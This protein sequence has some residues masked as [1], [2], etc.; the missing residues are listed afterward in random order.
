MSIVRG[1]PFSVT[2]TG[3]VGSATLVTSALTLGDTI[4][5]ETV[6]SASLLPVNGGS[7]SDDKGNTWVNV[8]EFSGISAGSGVFCGIWWVFSAAAGVTT[9]TLNPS[10]GGDVISATGRPVNGLTG[11][12]S[13]TAVGR[14][15][16]SATAIVTNVITTT[17]P[18]VLLVAVVG[19]FTGASPT[20]TQS[21]L[22][23]LIG[24]N[25]DGGGG[26]AINAIDL[27]LT[28]SGIFSA[29]W[30]MG[31]ATTVTS[32]IA[33]FKGT[34]PPPTEFGYEHARSKT[35]RSG[36]AISGLV[37]YTLGWKINGV[38]RGVHINSFTITHTIGQPSTCSFT[39]DG[40]QIVPGNQV[41]ISNDG[42]N[43]LL[44]GGVILPRKRRI[45]T[46][47]G[48]FYDVQCADWQWLMDKDAVVFDNFDSISINT[49]IRRVLN[50][51]VDPAL[52]IQ[53]GECSGSL[54][55]VSLTSI[56]D[57]PSALIA[58]ICASVKAYWQL[59]P[60]KYINV[61]QTQPSHAQTLQ[62]RNNSSVK[63]LYLGDDI[64]QIRNRVWYAGGGAQTTLLVPMGSTTIPVN[65]CGWYSD[66][67]GEGLALWLRF[68]Y[69][70]KSVSS[71]VGNLTGVA[72]L[73]GPADVPQG[74][75]VYVFSRLDDAT[76][77]TALATTLGGG[78]TG[79][80]IFYQADGNASIGEIAGR[81]QQ[82]RDF[83][84]DPMYDV[85]F[86]AA[87]PDYLENNA[88]HFKSGRLVDV[89]FTDAMSESV[90]GNFRVSSVT[91]TA[92][93]DV[94]LSRNE[95]G[96]ECLAL[97]R[98]FTFGPGVR[99]GITDLLVGG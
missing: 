58:R 55:T 22:F 13:G 77:Q 93:G 39:T 91:I 2:H 98:S 65:E 33:G 80:R 21:G 68:S 54:G 86:D 74:T 7:V 35:C 4:I 31:S 83:Y 52:G 19:H 87:F 43:S 44:F 5:I 61:F 57:A 12:L 37:P 62:I 56:G 84:G 28:S 79:I 46:G 27:I 96:Q 15:Q 97:N 6:T 94:K 20:I 75:S 70:G 51:Y 81:T 10:G 88:R 42:V 63:N 64:S 30:T 36:V 69:T 47:E 23:T 71:G 29:G 89:N 67:G 17:D 38:E 11:A 59:T 99:Q 8:I 26:A 24:E 40:F 78:L 92:L 16:T 41:V 25:E 82:H 95:Y 1:T 76:R 45:Q 90:V 60:D 85:T 14:N 49:A 50:N 18:D 9:I 66:T 53:L 73:N 72:W 48:I 32:V 3:F 34:A